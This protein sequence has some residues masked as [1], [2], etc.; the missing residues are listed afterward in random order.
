M[1]ERYVRNIPALSEPECRLLWQKRVAVIGC[2]GLGGYLV[3]LMARAGIGSIR[4]VDPDVFEES[5]L[6]RQLLSETGLAGCS[7][8]EAAR[9][10]VLRINPQIKAEA[11]AAAFRRENARTLLSGVD[12]VLDGLDSIPPRREL[13]EACTRMGIPYIY[14]AVSGWVGQAAVCMPGEDILSLLYPRDTLPQDKS[15]LSF[16][17]ALCA[18]MQAALCVKVLT[19]RPVETGVLHYVDLLGESYEAIHLA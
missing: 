17:P 2:G 8:A 13:A 12:A 4:A 15:V 1:E 7:K 5:N 6:N 10:R 14:G 3:E 11:V 16:A 18:S 19:G 9:N